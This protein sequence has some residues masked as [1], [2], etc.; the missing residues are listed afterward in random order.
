M[1]IE[2]F[3]AI[4]GCSAPSESASSSLVGCAASSAARARWIET[5]FSYAG[6]VTLSYGSIGQL[7]FLRQ[8][9][10]IPAY[11]VS[12][13]RD[14]LAVHAGAQA[15][16][17]SVELVECLAH[18]FHGPRGAFGDGLLRLLE[19]RFQ[20]AGFTR[21]NSVLPALSALA[22][23]PQHQPCHLAAVTAC[24]SK[25]YARPLLPLARPSYVREP[26]APARPR[27]TKAP[28]SLQQ[29]SAQARHTAADPRSSTK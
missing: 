24:D 11:P 25:R 19:L 23:S 8:R 1:K 21:M 14:D 27:P 22:W 12:T 16:G 20:L 3:S 5:R 2:D 13:G 4:C 7:G 17:D 18:Q 6:L 28:P 15:A 10:V 26:P 29:P 9:E